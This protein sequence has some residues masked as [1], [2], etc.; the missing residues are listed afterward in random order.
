MEKKK[1]A[2]YIRE[3]KVFRAFLSYNNF[4]D[5]TIFQETLHTLDIIKNSMI[6]M[7]NI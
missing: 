5:D 3:Q 1:K 6:K 7:V 4:I 2:N